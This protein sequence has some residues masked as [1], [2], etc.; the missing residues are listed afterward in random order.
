[1]IY[2]YATSGAT[3][4]YMWVIIA[5]A[6]IAIM[7]CAFSQRMRQENGS[8]NTERIVF[9]LVGG[10]INVFVAYLSLVVDVP[11]GSSTHTL[12]NGGGAPVIF[13]IFALL[14]FVNFAYSILAPEILESDKKEMGQKEKI[15]KKEEKKDEE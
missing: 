13:V 1:M 3:P 14:C 6:A 9:S 11:T 8:L 10:V 5:L 4:A 15:E 7:I 12:Y 2:T